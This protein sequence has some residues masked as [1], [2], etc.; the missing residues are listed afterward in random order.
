[1]SPFHEV[2]RGRSA[3]L[4]AAARDRAA[5]HTPV[6]PRGECGQTCAW[7]R[8]RTASEPRQVLAADRCCGAPGGRDRRRRVLLAHPGTKT[9]PGAVAEMNGPRRTV[10]PLAGRPC[11]ALAKWT[12][13]APWAG[14]V[15]STAPG[16]GL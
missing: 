4:W 2:A 15:P 8:R 7:C 13:H 10:K 14:P 5:G 16:P 12:W 1:V 6:L 9:C 3:A 11:C